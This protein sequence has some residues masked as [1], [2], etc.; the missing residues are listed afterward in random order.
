MAVGSVTSRWAVGGM[1]ALA[2]TQA[3]AAGEPSRLDQ[4]VERK[5]LNVCTTGDYRPFSYRPDGA[6]D[7]VGIDIDLGRSL[8][9]SLDAEAVFIQ[10]KWSDLL[11]DFKAK[12]DIAMS[13]ISVTLPRQREAFFS[14]MYLVNGKAPIV[15]CDDVA[16]YQTT[17][18]I[19]QPATRVV[20]NP[21]GTNEKFAR[22][23]L[24]DAQIRLFP[25]NRVIWREIAE[26]RADVMVAE[27]VEV[28]LQEKLH[29]GLCAVNPDQPLQYGEMGFLLP[30]G[31]AAFKAYV[32]QWLHLTKASGEF[33]RIFD[34][35]MK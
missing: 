10:T 11:A 1:L 34:A 25:D 35:N 20:V 19:N 29:P 33:A 32:D 8:A 23:N 21:G 24:G 18:A 2:A 7:F 15:R 22:A 5:V 6:N 14:E 4:V 31:D 16:K 26:G 3:L 27:S 28:K 13:G 9:K 12:C 30:R 17:K